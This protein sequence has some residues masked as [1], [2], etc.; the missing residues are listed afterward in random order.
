MVATIA[1]R[2]IYEVTFFGGDEGSELPMSEGTSLE[3]F[4]RSN[5]TI[6]IDI[7]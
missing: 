3:G 5:A 1:T 7:L 6:G 4:A 2:E